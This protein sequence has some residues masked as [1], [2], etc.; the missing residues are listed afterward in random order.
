[1]KNRL[2]KNIGLRNIFE[3][4]GFRISNSALEK[5][6]LLLQEPLKESLESVMRHARLSG[7]RTIKRE[8]IELLTKKS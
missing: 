3:K 6:S 1:M 7:R 2:I 4:R 8:D 5:I